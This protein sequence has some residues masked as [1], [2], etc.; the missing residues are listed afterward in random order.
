MTKYDLDFKGKNFVLVSKQTNY[1]ASDSCGIHQDNLK[2]SLD[3]MMS[4]YSRK[5]GGGCC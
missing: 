3:E 4:Q 1:L 2:V 5:L